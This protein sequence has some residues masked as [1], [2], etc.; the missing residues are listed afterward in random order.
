MKVILLQDIENLGKKFDV[1]EIADGYA[2]NF[3]IPKKMA[4]PATSSALAEIEKAKEQE[5][6]KAEEDLKLTQELASQIDGLEIEIKT[7]VSEDGNLF[8][9]I[10]S[11]RIVQALEE[12]G[13]KIDKSQIK[14][15]SPIKEVGEYSISI[16][17][18]HGLEAQIKLIVNAEDK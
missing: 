16:N 12:H 14:L 13:Y 9:S 18:N 2:R 5:V 11:Q 8:G 10:N 4:K 1:K 15:E 3:L 7:K 17:F 6:Q